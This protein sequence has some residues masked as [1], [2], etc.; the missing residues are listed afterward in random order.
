MK[1]KTIYFL[2]LCATLAI[3][4]LPALAQND[5]TPENKSAWYKDFIANYKGDQAKAYEPA[6]KY[7]ACPADATDTDDA[8]RTAYLQ[9]WVTA[10]E[11][12]SVVN[13][14]AKRKGQ[15]N[16]AITKKDYA[17]ALDLGRQILADEPDYLEGYINLS[18]AAY[19]AAAEGNKS[20]ANDGANYAKKAID[21][22][23]SGKAPADWK[24][25]K[26]EALAKLNYWLAS[27][28]LES[29]PAETIPYWIKAASSETFK[30]D[31]QAYYSLGVAYEAPA[32]K[33]IT[34]YNNTYNG[35]PESNESKLALENANQMIDRAID[36][37]ARA[38]A[39]AGSDAKYAAVKGD[40]ME[41]LTSWY[42]I[43]H[44]KTDGLNELIAGILSKP[45]PPEP[46][47]ITTLP[48]PSAT[49]PT[50]G[51]SNT[52]AGGTTPATAGGAKTG[53]GTKPPGKPKL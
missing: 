12:I 43:R 24:A 18:F 52:A 50:S 14:K 37:F 8:S 29:A 25:N 1:K 30:K 15:L 42:K 31:V 46:K 53:T 7:L 47:P 10:Y 13:E 44:E 21:I 2:S 36:A 6:K 45:L 9:K 39:L 5:C 11:K 33:Q 19:A 49:T 20:F 17:K 34:D 40:A 26:E 3:S 41:R 23:E 4:A 35:K 48:T 27:L 38:V 22:I 32:Q 51:A 16:E 28:K